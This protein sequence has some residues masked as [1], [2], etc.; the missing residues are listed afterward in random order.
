MTT[1]GKIPPEKPD[2]D[3]ALYLPEGCGLAQGMSVRLA[4]GTLVLTYA[5]K[6][7]VERLSPGMHVFTVDGA[8]RLVHAASRAPA[9]ASAGHAAD[10]S[11]QLSLNRTRFPGVRFVRHAS[12]IPY[13]DVVLGQAEAETP[14][15]ASATTQPG[16]PSAHSHHVAALRSI[17]E[18]VNIFVDPTEDRQAPR[19]RTRQSLTL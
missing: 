3:G 12:D 4:C 5:G 16:A 15:P 2:R 7:P 18:V 10:I 8:K 1:D 19:R 13:I 17:P 11:G 6:L 9:G 14:A